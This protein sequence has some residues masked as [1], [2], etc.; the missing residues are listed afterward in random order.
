MILLTPTR[1]PLLPPSVR[2]GSIQN[3]NPPTIK[4]QKSDLRETE[5]SRRCA[6]T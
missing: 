2:Q 5:I 6:V 4:F 1:V 3:P